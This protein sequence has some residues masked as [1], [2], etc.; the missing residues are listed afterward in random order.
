MAV[1][2][3]KQEAVQDEREQ[4]AELSRAASASHS[5]SP[6][7]AGGPSTPLKGSSASSE[8]QLQ[9]G[10]RRSAESGAGKRRMDV[11]KLPLPK[12]GIAL[13]PAMAGVSKVIKARGACA[14]ANECPA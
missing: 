9:S 6:P 8:R 14:S 13:V 1:Y 7:V 11:A 3:D 12:T 2:Y 10:L 4:E 5:A